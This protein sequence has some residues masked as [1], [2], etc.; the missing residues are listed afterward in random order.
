M[1]YSYKPISP[2]TGLTDPN[3][4][5]PKAVVIGAGLG[6]LS[7]AMRLGSKGYRVQIIDKLD[8]LGGRG[9]SIS[10][11]GY[12][13]DLGPTILTVPEVFRKLWQD[14]GFDFEKDV[15]L[16]ALDP[17]YEIRWQD[18][19]NF[20]VF[21]DETEML[22]EV[23]RK[24]PGDF[25][26]DVEVKG[27]GSGRDTAVRSLQNSGIEVTTIKDVTPIPHNGCRPPKRRRN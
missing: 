6:G 2:D 11:S 8:R 26:G 24:F 27:P 15:N 17:F 18:G 7:A 14:C 5:K 13:F 1:T 3:E 10:K 12:R 23:K 9:S 25:E 21:K 16:E 4:P 19:S 22:A 20:R